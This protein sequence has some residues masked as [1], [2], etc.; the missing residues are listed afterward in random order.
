MKKGKKLYHTIVTNFCKFGG[1]AIHYWKYAKNWKENQK[2]V[3]N[4][5]NTKHGFIKGKHVEMEEVK[6][7]SKKMEKEMKINKEIK[8]RFRHMD[9]V[10][11]IGNKNPF[12]GEIG[13]FHCYEKKYVDKER[14]IV[15]VYSDKSE[16]YFYPDEVI[17]KTP[18][19]KRI[20]P[21]TNMEANRFK[22]K[23]ELKTER[24]IENGVPK[25]ICPFCGYITKG[26][27]ATKMKKTT[28]CFH[29]QNV[30]KIKK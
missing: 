6:E 8:K 19:S 3:S 26:W 28:H 5:F 30:Y 27:L 14:L 17:M 1:D 2:L 25:I 23:K 16:H 13:E 18:Y 24:L 22:T 12:E 29:C 15:F 20:F 11:L 9:E 7:E 10:K 4:D 21:V